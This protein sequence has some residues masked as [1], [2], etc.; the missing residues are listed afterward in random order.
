ML[1]SQSPFPSRFVSLVFVGAAAS[2]LLAG[3]ASQGG[4]RRGEPGSGS[5]IPATA[6]PTLSGKSWVS[7]DGSEFPFTRWVAGGRPERVVVAI[8]GLSGAASDFWPLGEY[9]SSRSTAVYSY[10]LRGQGN[11]P[12]RDRIGDIRRPEQWYADLDTFLCLVRAEHPGVPIFL[13]GESLG[14]LI[15]VNGME[16]LG[17]PNRAAIR[18]LILASPV[19]SLKDLEAL[20]GVSYIALMAV[21]RLCPHRMISVEKLSE[22]K[23]DMKITGDTDHRENMRRTPHAVNAYSYRLLGTIKDLIDDSLEEAS[24]L[25]KP[26]LVL[27]PAHDLLT[28]PEAVEA[29]Y[30]RL[31]SEDK[32]RH[33]FERSFHLLLHDSQREEVLAIIGDWLD[34]H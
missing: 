29:W 21:I 20:P 12:Q 16:A 27:Y 18:G 25:Q 17:A 26:I 10:E 31:K 30:G 19:V 11:D 14:G 23:K 32:Q 5:G 4:G 8:H 13:Y 33:L 34:R 6:Q 9:L 1:R 15:S 7:S 22:G 28:T 24:E 2:A 3:C